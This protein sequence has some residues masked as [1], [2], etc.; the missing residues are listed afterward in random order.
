VTGTAVADPLLGT[1]LDRRY[2][3]ESVVAR[4]GMSTVYRGTDLRL[5]RRVAVKVMAP[6]LAADPA[7]VDR[8]VREARTAA[9]LSHPNAVAVTDQGSA[10]G[11]VF[12]VMELVEGSTLREVLRR[13]GRLR[14]AEAV[15]VLEPILAALA[16]AHRAGLVHRDVKPENV[17]LATDGTVKVVDFGL[18]RAVTAPSASTSTGMV[19]GTVAY[20]SPEQVAR[21][22][23]DARTDVYSAGILL[24]ELLTGAPPYGGDSALAVAYRHVHDDV[25]APSTV[26]PGVPPALDELV[27]RATSRE[28]GGRPTDAGAFLAELAMARADL[29]LPR[30]PPREV[31]SSLGLDPATVPADLGLPPGATRPAGGPRGAR[32]PGGGPAGTAALPRPPR[33]PASPARVLDGGAWPAERR[34]RRAARATALLA[35]LLVALGVG[36]TAWWF[37]SGRYVRVPALAGLSQARAEQRVA[38]AGL[39]AGIAEETSET[40]PDGQVLRSDPGPGDR[41][42][43]GRTVR[44]VVSSGRAPVSVPS[45][46]GQEQAAAVA[47]VRRAGLRPAVTEAASDD[48]AP[49]RVAAQSPAEGSLPRGG[50]VTLTVSTGPAVVRVP[51]VFGRS[52]ADAKRILTEAG[53]QVKVRSLTIGN[54]VAQSPRAGSERKR[55][56]TVTIYGL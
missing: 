15:S 1:V 54:V 48:V 9:R 21:G 8:F 34:R 26:V 4:G 37:G 23:A 7:F 2:R 33:P 45:V 27:L 38:A 24:F 18:A 22:V 39:D 11:V 10:G 19:L 46:V 52:V 51:S 42:L 43:R 3:V 5:D 49:G 50:A 13:R 44:V 53:F 12:L 14:P 56:S 28:P 47:A 32:G 25:P 40:V 36:G 17:L 6:A 29:G 20:V 55:G 16:A 30:V 35:V 31:A 41:V